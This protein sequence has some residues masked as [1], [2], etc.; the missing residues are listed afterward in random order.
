M[1]TDTA[2]IGS[3]GGGVIKTRNSLLFQSTA[4]PRKKKK[5]HK[6]ADQTKTKPIINSQESL[7]CAQKNS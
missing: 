4:L 2:Q 7:S 6:L 1:G 5:A 3:L